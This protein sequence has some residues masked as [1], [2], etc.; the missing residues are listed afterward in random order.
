[1]ED[2]RCASHILPTL[3][4]SSAG[5]VMGRREKGVCSMVGELGTEER[6]AYGRYYAE[7]VQATSGEPQDQFQA[8]LDEK[9]ARES[10]L[11]GVVRCLAEGCVNDFSATERPSFGRSSH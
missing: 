10:H 9:D 6:R 5:R 4:R 2:R 7:Y 8:L 1:M 3:H 11:L